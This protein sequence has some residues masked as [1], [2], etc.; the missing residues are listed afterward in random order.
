MDR[1]NKPLHPPKKN[2]RFQSLTQK[3]NDSKDKTPLCLFLSS[4][5]LFK[6][7]LHSILAAK[8][9]SCSQFKLAI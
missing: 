7:L 5:E 6:L 4:I 3:E 1:F 9:S 2:L 8:V